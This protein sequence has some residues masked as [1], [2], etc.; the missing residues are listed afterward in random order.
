M[1]ALMAVVPLAAAAQRQDLIAALRQLDALERFIAQSAAQ[2]LVTTGERYYF[3]YPRLLDDLAHVRAGIQFHL[4]PSRAQP[5]DL[6]ELDGDYRAE[7]ELSAPL[8]TQEQQP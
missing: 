7:T 4:T 6:Q 5:R 2:A 8:Q 1:T 3:D